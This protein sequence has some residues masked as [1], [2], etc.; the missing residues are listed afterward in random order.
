[1]KEKFKRMMEDDSALRDMEEK[2]QK[3][4]ES[5][6]KGVNAYTVFLSVMCLGIAV[7][8]FV[9]KD[10]WFG[11]GFVG[12]SALLG[13]VAFFSYRSEYKNRQNKEDNNKDE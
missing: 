3:R 13:V 5:S 11:L 9:Y 10:L 2:R 12:L 7:L 4:R 1:M 8:F 6:E